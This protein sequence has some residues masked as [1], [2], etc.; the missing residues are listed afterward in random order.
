M[1]WSLLELLIAAKNN[2]S[3]FFSQNLWSFRGS[4]GALLQYKGFRQKYKGK[5]DF[6]FFFCEF[7]PILFIKI[8]LKATD[9]FVWSIRFIWY[10]YCHTLCHFMPY[11]IFHKCHKMPFYGILWQMPYGIKW[12]KV[13]QYGYQMNRIDQTNWSMQFKIIFQEKSWTKNPEMGKPKFSFV[14]LAKFFV[15]FQWPVRQLK[16][17]QMDFL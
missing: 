4:N 15:F 16:W 12:C 11:G 8:I 3:R 6:P 7:R 9:W 17:P 13:W 10:P 5:F 2:N 1:T 14:F